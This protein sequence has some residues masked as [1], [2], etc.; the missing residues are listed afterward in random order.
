MTSLNSL[1][2][3]PAPLVL[4]SQSPRRRKLLAQIGLEFT[5]LVPDVNEDAV[6]VSEP[7]ST[8]VETL[9]SLKAKAVVERVV[10]D[11]LVIGADTT[12]AV[13]NTV[14]NKPESNQHA[15]QMLKTLSNRMHTVYTG[16]ALYLRL[17]SRITS[18]VTSS[19]TGVLF[20]AL[21]DNEIQAYVDTGEPLDK[22]GS[23]G[24]QDD[25]GAV[26]VREI[27]GCYY[28]VVGLPLELL[29][30]SLKQIARQ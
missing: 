5:S 2:Q 21:E 6:V 12:V 24:I 25:Y 29:Y 22:A 27:H 16:L 14:L 9:A 3:L 10:G 15:V 11:V 28:T 26:F 20:R 1:L 19:S 18:I 17:G 8:Y 13:N 7:F 30:T 4:A 23:Y